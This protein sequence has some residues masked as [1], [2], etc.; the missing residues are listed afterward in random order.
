MNEYAIVTWDHREQPDWDEIHRHQFCGLLFVIP[1]ESTGDDS[2][3][4]VMSKTQITIEQA[5]TVWDEMIEE[6]NAR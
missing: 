2:F 3:A 4:L 6:E 5:Q 1:V